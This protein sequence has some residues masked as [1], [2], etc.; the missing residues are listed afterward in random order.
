MT[1]SRLFLVF[2]SLV[3]V[4]F[5]VCGQRAQAEET[6]H[7]GHFQVVTKAQAAHSDTAPAANLYLAWADFA[8]FS[9]A[10]NSDGSYLW[11]CF[12]NYVASIGTSS[13]NVDC[14][15]IGD[16]SVPFGGGVVLGVPEY[17]WS[18]SDCNATT[19]TAPDC[20][21]QETFVED[22]TGDMT[23]E[24]LFSLEIVQ[25]TKIVY[26]T[27][28]QDY[29]PNPFGLTAAEYPVTWINYNP[30]N[31]GDMGIATGPNNG[32]CYGS[33]NY[34]EAQASYAGF[35]TVTA[36]KTCVPQFRAWLPAQRQS[37]SLQPHIQNRRRQQPVLQLA[38]IPVGQSSGSRNIRRLRSSPFGCSKHAKQ[39][40]AA[41]NSFFG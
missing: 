30:L 33:S 4:A 3:I 24:V 36:K 15:T 29:G 1:R 17:V 10:T 19:T 41:I 6:P 9:N 21:D 11:P 12:G 32:N 18:L 2:A 16:P 14:P 40:A 26:D 7:H 23:D 22:T 34:P 31:L 20:A 37:S 38:S 39:E 5:V 28:T 27:G 25:G 13:E 8:T 35:Y